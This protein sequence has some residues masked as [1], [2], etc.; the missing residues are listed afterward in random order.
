[1]SAQDQKSK[2]AAARQDKP[3]RPPAQPSPGP[4]TSTDRDPEEEGSAGRS[5]TDRTHRGGRP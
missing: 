4:S 5:P 3:D 2:N 1:M